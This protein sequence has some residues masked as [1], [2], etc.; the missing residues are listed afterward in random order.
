[1]LRQT[2]TAARFE[3]PMMVRR[4]APRLGE[5]NE[6]ILRELSL[7]ADEIAALHKEGIVGPGPVASANT[8]HR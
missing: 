3:A 6:E 4:G 8:H 7:S 5:H 2:R 1:M